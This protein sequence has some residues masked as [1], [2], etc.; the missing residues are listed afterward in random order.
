MTRTFFF[1]DKFDQPMKFSMIS[2]IF[3]GN[4]ESKDLNVCEVSTYEY[5]IPADFDLV[6]GNISESS[7]NQASKYMEYTR[8]HNEDLS[9]RIE[10]HFFDK[11]LPKLNKR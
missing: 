10:N 11:K 4:S 1:A 6:T 9:E 5:Y 2:N 8:Q 3:Y 7:Q